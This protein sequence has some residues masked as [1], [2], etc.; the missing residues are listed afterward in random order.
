MP[1]DK[2][3]VDRVMEA[4]I[5]YEKAARVAAVAEGERITAR[6]ALAEVV[7]VPRLHGDDSI[8]QEAK[9]QIGELMIAGGR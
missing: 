9:V 7:G 4:V 3:S 6:D 2:S 8:V 5:R 1:S